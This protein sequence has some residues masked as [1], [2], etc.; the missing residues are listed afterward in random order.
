MD[1]LC[2]ICAAG[3]WDGPAAQR[4]TSRTRAGAVGVVVARMGGLRL[5]DKLVGLLAEIG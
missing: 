4:G 2:N 5:V 3:T 1:R